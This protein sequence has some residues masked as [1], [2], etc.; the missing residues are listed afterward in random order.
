MRPRPAPNAV[1]TATSRNR[2]VARAN[3]RF[4]TLTHAISSTKQT[5]ASIMIR[6]SL[7]VRSTINRCDGHSA[8]WRFL[9]VSG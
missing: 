6:Y 5:E 3:C 1:R 2:P 8:K 4:A 9:L 7:V